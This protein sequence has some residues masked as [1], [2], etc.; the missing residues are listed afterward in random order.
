MRIGLDVRDGRKDR[1]DGRIMK[2]AVELRT[3]SQAIAG[4]HDQVYSGK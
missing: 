2:L 1:Y 4:W 3:H